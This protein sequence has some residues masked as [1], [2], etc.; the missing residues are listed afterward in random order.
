MGALAAAAAW[1]AAQPQRRSTRARLL[2][3]AREALRAAPVGLFVFAAVIVVFYTS[4]F[5]YAAGLQGFFEA[6]GP[7]IEYGTTG[8]N[9][10]KPF[11]YFWELM[12][13]T[14]GAYRFLALPAA[15]LACV[16]RD[17]PGLALA[18]WTLAAFLLYSAIPYKTPW[19]VLEIDLPVFWLVGW[20]AGSCLAAASEAARR[21]AVRI[22]AALAFAAA[23]APAPWL[24]AQSLEDVRE[25]YDDPARPYVYFHTQR[26]FF[27][28]LQ[29]LFGVADAAPDADGRG[30]RVV[31]SEA[32]D[33]V[34]WYLHSRGWAPERTRY[35]ENPAPP[36]AW[37]DEAQIYNSLQVRKRA[38]RAIARHIQCD[39]RLQA[40]HEFEGVA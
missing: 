30:P 6:F 13:A 9:Q 29:D 20:A 22:A 8:R 3:F 40:L 5:R 19:C 4:F 25:R 33:P 21:P 39:A 34:R 16:R 15:L 37:I 26:S 27:A 38:G 32:A 36:L 10:A 35:L 28:M 18:G 1:L 12:A 14:E 24:L 17:P 23:L 7:W 31:N 2:A 11:G